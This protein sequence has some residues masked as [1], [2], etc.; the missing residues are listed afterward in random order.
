MRLCSNWVSKCWFAFQLSLV[1]SL[2]SYFFSLK[3]VECRLVLK[4]QGFNYASCMACDDELCSSQNFKQHNHLHLSID[5]IVKN[6]HVHIQYK[7]IRSW[8]LG[9]ML[10]NVRV[11]SPSPVWRVHFPPKRK[12]NTTKADIWCL[13]HVNTKLLRPSFMRDWYPGW[14][15]GVVLSTYGWYDVIEIV[16]WIGFNKLSVLLSR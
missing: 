3:K 6:Y 4:K 5:A 10:L 8:V 2:N 11:A 15:F 9:P 13:E 1:L 12:V 14:N 7:L 16:N